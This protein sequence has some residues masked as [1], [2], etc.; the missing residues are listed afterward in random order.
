MRARGA[1]IATVPALVGGLWAQVH[2]AAHAPLPQFDDLDLTG[3]Y[4]GGTGDSRTEPVRVAVMGDSTL[5]GPGL[6]HP[7]EVFVARAASRLETRL[8]LTRFA[9]GGSRIGDV[10]MHQLPAVLDA[11]PDVAVISIG[12]NDAIHATPLGQ[13]ERDVRAVIGALDRAG[14]VTLVCG[15]LDLSVIPRVPSALKLMLAMRGAA[16]E[17]RK[18]RAVYPAARAVHVGVTPAVNQAFRARGEEFFT[19]D[20]FHPNA[21]GHACLADGLGPY[22]EAAVHRIDQLGHRRPTSTP[23]LP[24]A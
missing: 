17:R 21:A 18:A 12:A 20:R 11:A 22:L 13:F 2:R 7:S 23:P 6:D 4:G 24:L 3:T 10:F 15:L 19:A 16:Y 8:Q 14:I 5:T 9:V 1:A